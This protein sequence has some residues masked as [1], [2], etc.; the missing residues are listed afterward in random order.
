MCW[1][2]QHPRNFSKSF[3]KTLAMKAS[4]TWLG[5]CWATSAAVAA[6][7]CA[8][9]KPRRKPVSMPVLV[10]TSATSRRSLAASC[11]STCGEREVSMLLAADV[12]AL[13]IFQ[14]VGPAEN[15][16]FEAKKRW[17]CPSLVDGAAAKDQL[18]LSKQA[19]ASSRPAIETCRARPR[20]LVRPAIFE[21]CTMA[22]K[23][24]R[25]PG[26]PFRCLRRLTPWLWPIQKV[27]L[28]LFSIMVR[29]AFG[30]SS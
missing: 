29:K 28:I 14:V 6:A 22:T 23:S 25:R 8:A 18:R 11:N 17:R 19:P 15:W 24:A 7:A 30:K 4:S 21:T 26:A 9:C 12:A 2:H 1:N 20:P 27:V 13:C 3:R 10:A 16:D 5:G